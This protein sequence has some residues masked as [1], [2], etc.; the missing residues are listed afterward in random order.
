M[1]H[2]FE[3]TEAFIT[4]RNA[5]WGRPGLRDLMIIELGHHPVAALELSQ[6]FNP[7]SVPAA[8]LQS[9]SQEV[10][11]HF[12]VKD[13]FELEAEDAIVERL[14]ASRA[15]FQKKKDKSWQT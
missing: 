1:P 6:N 10:D 7:R 13:A 4:E 8:D 12:D 15:A 3:Q 9:R 5:R 2:L 14:E 11:T